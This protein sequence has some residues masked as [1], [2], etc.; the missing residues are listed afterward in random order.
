M[1][2]SGFSNLI[3]CCRYLKGIC[4]EYHQSIFLFFDPHN[5]KRVFGVLCLSSTLH[6]ILL[7]RYLQ[8]RCLDWH[9]SKRSLWMDYIMFVINVFTIQ[10]ECCECCISPYCFTKLFCDFDGVTCWSF[11]SLSTNVLKKHLFIQTSKNERHQCCVLPKCFNNW[12]RSSVSNI[13]I[14]L[15]CTLKEQIRPIFCHLMFTAQIK[16]SE[17]GVCLEWFTQHRCSVISNWIAC[18]NR[19]LKKKKQMEWVKT[20]WCLITIVPH[21]TGQAYGCF[22]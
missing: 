2:Q 11:V 10:N 15:L 20:C 5:S 19:V 1:F 18:G 21:Q 6:T 8:S 14:W 13:V 17:C 16:F 7:L 9:E 22:Y 12:C 3:D 4:C